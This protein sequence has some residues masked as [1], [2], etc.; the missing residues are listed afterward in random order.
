[1]DI[2]V[3]WTIQASLWLQQHT[4]ELLED[5]RCAE[6]MCDN[7][8][9]CNET[10]N[11]MSIYK[12]SS[13]FSKDPKLTATSV[14]WSEYVPAIHMGFVNRLLLK[15]QSHAQR[16][17]LCFRNLVLRQRVLRCPT[18][19]AP[20]TGALPCTSWTCHTCSI[21]TRVKLDLEQTVSA[22]S[23][24]FDVCLKNNLNAMEL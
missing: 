2:Y 18:S 16:E 9:T 10:L 4:S 8:W 17:I 12:K 3:L 15:T 6:F 1:M 14:G 24:F 21:E 13:S 11:V 20:G 5:A 22:F 23:Y 19:T 7:L